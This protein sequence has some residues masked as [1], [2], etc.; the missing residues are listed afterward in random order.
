M[1]YINLRSCFLLVVT[2]FFPLLFL[3]SAS[4]NTVTVSANKKDTARLHLYV[5]QSG[6]PVSALSLIDTT[7]QNLIAKTGKL[8]EVHKKMPVADYKFAL[9]GTDKRGVQVQ[10]PLEFSLEKNES[11]QFI[12]TLQD[13]QNSSIELITES[14]H[15]ASSNNKTQKDKDKEEPEV[16]KIPAVFNATIEGEIRSLEGNNP[17][18]GAKVFIKGV[19]KPIKTD[20]NGKFSMPAPAG[21]HAI[22]VIHP[23]FSTLTKNDVGLQ[24]NETKTL[25]LE[26]TP[27]AIEL[28][29]YT[30]TAP[31]IE[32]GVLALTN[33]KRKSSAVVEVIGEDQISNSGDSDAGGALKRV[34][35]LTL[36]GGK[37]VYVRG[38]GERYSSIT[39]N[40]AGIPSPDPTRKVVPL[41]LFPA[42]ILG[43]V[44]VQKT[45]APNMAADFGG[46]TI[47][48]RTKGVP[49]EK[50]RKLS[51]STGYNSLSTGKKGDIYDG[52]DTDFLGLDD[53]TRDFPSTLD[54]L[55]QGGS[56]SLNLLSKAEIETAGES[57][58]NNYD[59]FG[60][61][62]PA[63]FG[64]GLTMGNLNEIYGED[65]AWGYNFNI[66][67]NN[68][69]RLR[70]DSKISYISNGDK[71]ASG[72]TSSI[73]RTENEI[74]LS[75]MLNMGVEIGESTKLESITILSR[76][77]TNNI[78][79]SDDFL[80]EN[81]ESQRKTILEWV[82]RQLISQQF[83]GE[84][85]FYELNDMQLNWQLSTSQAK[86]DEPDTREYSYQLNERNN[87]YE[88]VTSGSSAN[89]FYETLTD[90]STSVGFD[91][92][93]PVYDFFG[94]SALFKTGFL[95]ENKERESD[96]LLFQFFTNL[97]RS[98]IDKDILSLNLESILTPEN[99]APDRYKLLNG[100]RPTDSY[101]ADQSISATYLMTEL[102]FD[103]YKFMAGVRSERF[104]LEVVT[105]SL[106]S[107]DE[108]I[109]GKLEENDL[110]PAF[111]ATWIPSPKYQFRIAYSETT[112]RPDFKELSPA[113]YTDPETRDSVKGNS[114]LKSAFI[115]HIDFRWEYYA[116][117]FEGM[118]VALFYK[119]FTD[120]IE[121]II[122]VG[123]GG[124]HTFQNAES[125]ENMGI[126]FQG[127]F[128]LSRV[129]G[130]R[131]SRF[132]VDTNLTLIDSNVS[133]GKAAGLQTTDNRPLQG[134]APWLIN[135]NIT[136]ENLIARSK[137]SLL[138]NMTGESID[139]VGLQGLP[140]SYLEPVAQLD[141][142]YGQE[143]F[144]DF[145]D[146]REDKLKL[147]LKLKNILDSEHEVTQ[148]GEP[149][150]TYR[151]GRSIS[152][153]LDYSWQ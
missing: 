61:N 77:T 81:D 70:E 122:I 108:K 91:I 6:E 144:T 151:K 54:R 134:Q 136:Y 107:P 128:W 113:P 22:A 66:K 106:S 56:K 105:F 49:P 135:F 130:K 116:T 28:E 111:S 19:G 4:A 124:E 89:R 93:Y 141:F 20:F 33:E 58:V 120:P 142:V 3:N 102:D 97:S 76:N 26:L 24:E 47:E 41:D 148:G 121:R 71:L 117:G 101:T 149:R 98:T 96:I 140:D 43:S 85:E 133:L 82:E 51:L 31:Y 114:K 36:I 138:F 123:A 110:F 103:Q 80:S 46:G 152:L 25:L 44:R 95:S 35:G 86:R 99:I 50:L 125:A 12:I 68:K 79:L 7:N 18:P 112:N 90:K 131:A 104:D 30:V 38:L 118:S 127:R 69:W 60:K 2:A 67:Y 32:T 10:Y 37:F 65:W 119:D 45:Y 55:S 5:F 72:D 59:T 16:N 27:S 23:D 129:F 13:D 9:V 87:K 84:H 100:T 74:N 75:S 137:A 8:G 146:Q 64:V 1:K 11:L 153:S 150:L 88:V 62:L 63:D 15:K 53:G 115:N 83:R 42:N 92:S 34:T 29:E 145:F 94:G 132:Y 109:T 57:L 139:T 14:S 39:M 143:V 48:L 126:E 73:K 52:G 17:I 40:N 78:T 147:K 21:L